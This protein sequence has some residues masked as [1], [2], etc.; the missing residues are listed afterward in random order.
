MKPVLVPIGAA[1]GDSPAESSARDRQE[2]IAPA[3]SPS[4]PAHAGDNPVA[5]PSSTTRREKKRGA[6]Y[7]QSR[8]ANKPTPEAVAAAL[9]DTPMPEKDLTTEGRVDFCCDSCGVTVPT[10]RGDTVT[11]KKLNR[12]IH[13]LKLNCPKCNGRKC[14]E[15]IGWSD[16][17]LT[18]QY[19]W[20]DD[21]GVPKLREFE[22][23]K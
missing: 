17:A 1:A 18:P 9:F 20:F 13:G 19:E 15:R 11:R 7:G 8:D 21:A 6:P 12:T 14:C 4:W 10:I 2:T 16:P 23:A 5:P 3:N 22:V